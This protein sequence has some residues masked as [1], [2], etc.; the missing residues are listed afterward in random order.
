M[1]KLPTFYR[2]QS[3]LPY[4]RYKSLWPCYVKTFVDFLNFIHHP[5]FLFTNGTMWNVQKFYHYVNCRVGTNLILDPTL[6]QFNAL[7]IVTHCFRFF[8]IY[9]MI[10]SSI[11]V[12]YSGLFHFG[13]AP[14]ILHAS[15]VSQARATCFDNLTF[16]DFITPIIF[17]EEYKLWSSSVC[18][19]LRSS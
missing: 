9:F 3:Q 5:A 14:N 11:Q 17:C 15:L 10:T 2:T 1:K 19:V 7:H 13:F 12:L 4:I 6:S 16:H 18:E 8:E